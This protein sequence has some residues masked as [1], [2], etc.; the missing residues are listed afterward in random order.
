MNLF[1]R[2]DYS[3]PDCSL[4]V[5]TVNGL[6]LQTLELPWVADPTCKGGHPDKS[7]VPAATYLLA[8]HDSA[9]HPKSFA[10]VNSSLS[11]YHDPAD[12]PSGIVGRTDILIHT[13]NWAAQLAGC[14]AV[15]R[16]RGFVAE[17]WMITQSDDAYAAFQAAVPWVGGHSLTVTYAPGIGP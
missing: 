5:L 16:E 14:C 17:R 9:D 3:G 4:G 6:T 8:L 13:A 7:C 2:R 12:V 11:V 15:G 1:L 10:L